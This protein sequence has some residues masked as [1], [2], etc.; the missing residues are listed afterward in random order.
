MAGFLWQKGKLTRKNQTGKLAGKVV[1]RALK[2]S[3]GTDRSKGLKRSDL[4]SEKMKGKE[5]GK[6]RW[7]K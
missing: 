1:E 4:A 5:L 6:S 3:M 2:R 7:K